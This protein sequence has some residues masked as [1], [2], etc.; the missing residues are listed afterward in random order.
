MFEYNKDQDKRDTFFDIVPDPYFSK[1]D[2]QRY[3]GLNVETLKILLDEKFANPEEVQNES[4]SIQEFYDFMVKF[5]EFTAHGYLI[6]N[7]RSDYRVSI[8]GLIGV[9]SDFDAERAF[10]RMFRQADEFDFYPDGSFRC[11]YD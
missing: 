2:Y 9:P 4:P 10:S 8:E 3:H 6:G 7:G 5:P 1:N 11:W